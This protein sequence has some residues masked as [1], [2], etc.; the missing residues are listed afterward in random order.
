MTGSKRDRLQAPASPHHHD[1]A[2]AD[3]TAV[4]YKLGAFDFTKNRSRSK[5]NR[6]RSKRSSAAAPGGKNQ[7]LATEL[8]TLSFIAQ[9]A[10]EGVANRSR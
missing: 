5:D 2:T 8:A 10:D 1:S 4:A 9:R 3:E 7:L 6:S